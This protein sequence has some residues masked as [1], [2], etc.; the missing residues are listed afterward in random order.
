MRRK[1]KKATA[2]NLRH[3]QAEGRGKNTVPA[4]QFS[5]L[6]FKESLELSKKDYKI[7]SYIT[8]IAVALFTFVTFL[9]SLI[10]RYT[11]VPHSDIL[12]LFFIGALPLLFILALSVFSLPVILILHSLLHYGVKKVVKKLESLA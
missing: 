8:F 1:F 7:I 4:T 9:L 12:P 2:Q 10:T 3:Y 5:V 11:A 6:S